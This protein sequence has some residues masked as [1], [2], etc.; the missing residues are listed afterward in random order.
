[1]S[2]YH[3]WINLLGH[4]AGVL[5]F[6]IFL[7]LMWRRTALSAE[8]SRGLSLL[9]AAL[10]FLWN[11]TSLA[12]ITTAGKNADLLAGFG[13]IVLSILPAVLL[14][15]CL[16]GR[17]R[18][19]IRLG[20]GLSAL[21]VTAH[22]VEFFDQSIA[23]HRLGLDA[24]TGGFGLLTLVAIIVARPA[25]SKILAVMSLFLFAMSFVHFSEGQTH[26]VWSA[27][28]AVH[29]AGIPLAMFV[30]L[31]DYR[32]VLLDAFIRFLANG[33]L[34]MV[35]AVLIAN[36]PA[37]PVAIFAAALGLLAFAFL[38]ESV[39]K[40]LTRAVFRQPD[41]TQAVHAMQNLSAHRSSEGSFLDEAAAKMARWMDAPLIEMTI[42]MPDAAPVAPRLAGA[43]AIVPIRLSH[44]ET[45][46]ALLGERR[47]GRPYLSEDL[48]LLARL[49]VEIARLVESLREAEVR[50]L[51]SEA[52][53]RAL[54]AQ[55]HPH[56]LFNALNT[57]YGVIPREAPAARRLLLNLADIFRYFLRPEAAFVTVEEEMRIVEAYLSIESFRLGSKLHVEIEVGEA[58]RSR[59]IPVLSIQPLVENAVKHGV[60]SRPEGGNIRIEVSSLEDGVR[61]SVADSGPGFRAAGGGNGLGVGL[62]NVSRRLE[63]CYGTRSALTVTSSDDGACVSFVAP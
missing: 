31:H 52:E 35:F 41:F 12:V 27:E 21:A 44:G 46:T 40:F 13:F 48:D 28:L 26:Q 63:V 29:H 16:D 11:L 51:I 32:F 7:F 36:A 18:W 17:V 8:Q 39:Q 6:G 23:Y 34:A 54:Q 1:M 38:R 2:A 55:I 14:H 50:R 3:V 53:L 56:F 33:L 5:V 24:I 15:L 60:S 42:A 25:L 49:S 9:A 45:R 61:V 20:Y 4:G 57:L 19:L 47:G 62:K 59:T 10:A 37:G 22:L 43:G 58:A 30:L